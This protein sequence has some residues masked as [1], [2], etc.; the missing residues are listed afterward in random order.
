[1]KFAESRFQKSSAVR[2]LDGF[3]GNLD[4]LKS[5]FWVSDFS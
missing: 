1:M 2:I 3:Y 4:L 5:G